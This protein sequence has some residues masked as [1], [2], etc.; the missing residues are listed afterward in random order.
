MHNMTCMVISFTDSHS[1]DALSQQLF[2]LLRTINRELKVLGF[3]L[4]LHDA[5]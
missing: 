5:D 4:A 2:D 3:Q 1:L